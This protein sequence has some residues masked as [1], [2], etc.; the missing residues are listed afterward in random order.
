MGHRRRCRCDTGAQFRVRQHSGCGRKL[1]EVIAEW[2]DAN[3]ATWGPWVE[4]AKAA[5]AAM[6]AAEE[7]AAA[8]AANA[9]KLDR[10][11]EKVMMK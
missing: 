6:A 8:G 7:A 3:E 2:I 4:A 5:M 10:M 1:E 9:E 11:F